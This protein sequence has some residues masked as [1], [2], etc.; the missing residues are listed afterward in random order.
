MGCNVLLAG[1]SDHL[2]DW[3]VLRRENGTG[4]ECLVYISAWV[5]YREEGDFSYFLFYFC[6]SVFYFVVTVVSLN[7][8]A[9]GWVLLCLFL[10]TCIVF[11]LYGSFNL[12]LMHRNSYTCCVK[13]CFLSIFREY[14]LAGITL[15]CLVKFIIL[16]CWFVHPAHFI[17]I[18][19][20]WKPSSNES[21]KCTRKDWNLTTDYGMDLTFWLER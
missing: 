3:K 11:F 10:C 20:C 5:G 18:L 16:A 1:E 4:G 7:R 19:L 21:S 17:T 12:L 15:N 9:R 2:L 8:H 6:T 14:T 13:I